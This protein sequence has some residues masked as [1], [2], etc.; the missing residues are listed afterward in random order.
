MIK[1]RNNNE[2]K[3]K[4]LRK[5]GYYYF[6]YQGYYYKLMIKTESVYC[7]L[8]YREN[9]IV[10]INMKSLTIRDIHKDEWV[11]PI[12]NVN[13]NIEVEEVSSKDLNFQKNNQEN[14]THFVIDTNCV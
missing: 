9:H 6:K 2:I 13:C 14:F 4:D 1:T 7:S 8:K 11:L 10:A 12:F 5:N 3:L